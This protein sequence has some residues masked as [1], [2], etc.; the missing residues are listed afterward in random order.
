MNF[1]FWPFLWFGLPGRLLNEGTENL[2]IK[3]G[4]SGDVT[5]SCRGEG[6]CIASDRELPRSAP[7]AR[8]EI[9]Q[10]L[11]AFLDACC[12]G[13]TYWPASSGGVSWR[14]EGQL[15]R[16]FKRG[17]WKRSMYIKCV[18]VW[19]SN[20]RQF[21]DNFAHPPCDVRTSSKHQQFCANLA[22]SLRNP[23]WRKP[24]LETSEFTESEKCFSVAAMHLTIPEIPPEKKQLLPDF[25]LR[26]VNIQT[27]QKYNSIPQPFHTLPVS[28]LFLASLA[29]KVIRAGKTHKL[30][31]IARNDPF[32]AWSPPTPPKKSVCE[33][34]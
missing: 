14:R 15:C 18:G 4:G 19:L 16:M 22:C 7:S 23:P 29:P 27:P 28:L 3:S 30:N 1:S 33:S 32:W 10:G 5:A 2:H 9:G 20:L 26:I 24:L 11:A 13:F 34:D 6:S 31:A 21:C 12:I 8:T 17:D 25:R